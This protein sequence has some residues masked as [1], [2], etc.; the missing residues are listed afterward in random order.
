MYAVLSEACNVANEIWIEL[1]SLQQINE[2]QNLS[3]PIQREMVDLKLE[4]SQLLI[5]ML[6]M[7]LNE[8]IQ[9]NEKN[10]G[11]NAIYKVF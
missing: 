9:Q 1:E 4:T 7:N 10:M 2:T 8:T 11:K 6:E 5:D 3:L